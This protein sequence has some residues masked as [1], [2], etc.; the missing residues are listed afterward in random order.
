MGTGY[1]KELSIH[2]FGSLEEDYA[3]RIHQFDVFEAKLEALCA[4]YGLEIEYT[5]D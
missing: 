5:L 1:S 4:E 2:V 3:D